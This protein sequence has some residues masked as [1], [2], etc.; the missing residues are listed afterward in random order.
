MCHGLKGSA[1]L[2]VLS[3]NVEPRPTFVA[4]IDAFSRLLVNVFVVEAPLSAL[5]QA[6][7]LVEGA[8]PPISAFGLEFRP[9]GVPQRH[10]FPEKSKL[11]QRVPLR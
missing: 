4:T 7:Y 1:R 5:P 3:K 6:H 2:R 8:A 10:G 9:S 11:L